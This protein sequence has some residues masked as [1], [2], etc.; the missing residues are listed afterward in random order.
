MRD[1]DRQRRSGRERENEEVNEREERKLKKNDWGNITGL[2]EKGKGG[3]EG[4][5][6][7]GN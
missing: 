1:I 5:Q 3:S 4:G 7:E 2:Q 6:A